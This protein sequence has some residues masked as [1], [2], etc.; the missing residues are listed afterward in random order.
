[1]ITQWILLLLLH[2]H[3][4]SL[5]IFVII[6]SSPECVKYLWIFL[7]EVISWY[8]ISESDMKLLRSF[9][10]FDAFA[11]PSDQVTWLLFHLES[12]A[13]IHTPGHSQVCIVVIWSGCQ[14][15]EGFWDQV[16]QLSL[17]I[18]D[19]WHWIIIIKYKWCHITII[20]YAILISL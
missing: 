13:L 5:I 11:V 19:D 12:V 18:S 4:P 8:L 15:Y 9:F 2:L 20:I 6:F 10:D 7:S 14:V 17:I 16:I 3:C 1:M